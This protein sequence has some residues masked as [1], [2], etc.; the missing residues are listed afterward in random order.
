ME[1]DNTDGDN[2]SDDGDKV[3][4]GN[5]PKGTRFKKGGKSPNPGGRPK[6]SVSRKDISKLSGKDLMSAEILRL[7]NQTLA[8]LEE[9][10]SKEITLIEAIARNVILKAAKGDPKALRSFLDL[11]REGMSRVEEVNEP[12]HKPPIVFLPINGF[13]PPED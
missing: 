2:G 5:P 3:G 7:C 1:N 6:G 4:F 13:E 9:E 11:F 8:S 10:P 12:A